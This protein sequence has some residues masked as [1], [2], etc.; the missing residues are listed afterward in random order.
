MRTLEGFLL[1]VSAEVNHQGVFEFED[2]RTKFTG[3]DFQLALVQA[4]R[5][6]VKKKK[7]NFT[8]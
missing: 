4:V 3:E 5:Q 2:L 6:T 8:K 7:K 1:G